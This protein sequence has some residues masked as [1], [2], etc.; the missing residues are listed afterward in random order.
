M[1]TRVLG[2]FP[3]VLGKSLWQVIASANTINPTNDRVRLTGNTLLK[4]INRPNQD[5]NGPLYII[6]TDA[7]VGSWDALGNIA[8][9]G[10]FVRY[11]VFIFLYDTV[12]AKWYPSRIA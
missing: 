11:H 7:V 9:G 12:T 3:R 6:N 8:I 5:F 4:T 2:D 10:A 1:P